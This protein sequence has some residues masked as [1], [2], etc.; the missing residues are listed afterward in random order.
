MHWLALETS[1]RV[2][3][4]A[5]GTDDRCVEFALMEPRRLSQEITDLVMRILESAR[6]APD[7]LDLVVVGR[8]P[9][10][11][12]G[13]RIGLSFAQAFAWARGIRC[14]GVPSS[15]AT[16]AALAPQDRSAAFYLQYGRAGEVA[17]AE[18]A[19]Q[20]DGWQ[21][22]GPERTRTIAEL[23]TLL[24]ATPTPTLLCGEAADEL[25]ME[26]DANPQVAFVPRAALASELARYARENHEAGTNCSPI[27]A[28]PSSAELTFGT[29]VTT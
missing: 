21:K 7:Q 26:V 8:G 9:G 25:R 16:I 1:T 13:L 23:R 2:P 5:A 10:S 12:T 18:F 17:V 15:N 27:Y 3:T 29:V 20:G 6:L 14:C 28:A 22:L 19:L 4:V 11:W 24:V